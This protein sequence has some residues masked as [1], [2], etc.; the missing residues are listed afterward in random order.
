MIPSADAVTVVARRRAGLVAT[1]GKPLV[2]GSSRPEVR[3]AVQ[4]G[5]HSMAPW[6][7]EEPVLLLS[8]PE[9]RGDR[10]AE[11]LTGSTVPQP[12]PQP[13]GRGPQPAAHL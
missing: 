2:E 11:R 3:A 8:A 9:R 7:E 4:L 1:V 10:P 13:A 5:G 12:A 6:S